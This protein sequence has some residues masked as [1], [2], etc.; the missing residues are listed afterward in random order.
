MKSA[1]AGIGS[2]GQRLRAGEECVFTMGKN[3]ELLDKLI[4]ED[5]EIVDLT[6]DLEEGIPSCAT[7]ARFGRILHES[8]EWGNEFTHAGLVLGEHTGTHMDSPNHHIPNCDYT[9]EKVPLPKLFG[10]GCWIEC[11]GAEKNSMIGV[12]AVK[13]WEQANGPIKEGDFV[14]FHTGWDKYWGVHPACNQ[15]E[16]DWPGINRGCAEY[17]RDKG[18]V[19]VGT[20]TLALDRG[21][22]PLDD[23]EAHDVILGAR[24]TI[25]EGVANL[26][27]LPPVFYVVALP[28]KVKGGSGSTTRLVALV[29]K[30]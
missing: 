17:L 26:T 19:T 1:F 11:D 13:A 15:F 22:A 18:V 21:D 23:C 20:D 8:I 28:M 4:H 10:R 29:E 7:H 25:M 9:I 14:F 6:H 24:L 16:S 2:P 27:K 5:F 3:I 12:E 30:E